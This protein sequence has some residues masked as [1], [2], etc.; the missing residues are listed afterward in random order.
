[1]KEDDEEVEAEAG[2][3]A[4]QGEESEPPVE[5]IEPSEQERQV[6]EKNDEMGRVR[7]DQYVDGDDDELTLGLGNE[8][9]VCFDNK[10]VVVGAKAAQLL[11]G[12]RAER[13]LGH[14]G[15]QIAAHEDRDK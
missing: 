4:E 2:R 15:Q 6:E 10:C 12:E 8:C 13:D 5:H 14:D 9:V 11:H 3:R 7:H 1:M